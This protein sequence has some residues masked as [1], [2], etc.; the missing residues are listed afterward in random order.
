MMALTTVETTVMKLQI[1][2][3]IAVSIK[4]QKAWDVTTVL[5][6][7]LYVLMNRWRDT[8]KTSSCGNSNF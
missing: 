6:E 8:D 7:K 2:V 1:R 5:G 4:P 3:H